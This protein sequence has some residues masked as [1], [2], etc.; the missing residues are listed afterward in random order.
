MKRHQQQLVEAWLLQN[1]RLTKRSLLALNRRL[2]CQK[3]NIFGQTER[4]GGRSK[5]DGLVKHSLTAE[6]QL[7]RQLSYSHGQDQLRLGLR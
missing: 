3:S 1:G 5:Y 7:T 4:G 2:P 6:T